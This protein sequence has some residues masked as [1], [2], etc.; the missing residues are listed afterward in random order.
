M[1]DGSSDP[2]GAV[3]AAQESQESVAVEATTQ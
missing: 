1:G 2:H 3:E